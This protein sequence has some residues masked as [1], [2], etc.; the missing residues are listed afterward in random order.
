[1]P[2]PHSWF[3]LQGYEMP[4]HSLRSMFQEHGDAST[5]FSLVSP[6]VF[7]YPN[8]I[9]GCHSKGIRCLC[10]P[11]TDVP[12]KRICPNQFTLVSPR[13]LRCLN[14]TQNCHSK[15]MRCLCIP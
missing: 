12:R 1:M 7:R 9:H 5:Q 13:V 6:R 14:P 11:R 15:G 10:I 8:P 3:P 2:Q 4:L